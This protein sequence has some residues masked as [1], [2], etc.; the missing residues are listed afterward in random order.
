MNNLRQMK[1]TL[2]DVHIM[3]WQRVYQVVINTDE[4]PL[5]RCCGDDGYFDVGGLIVSFLIPLKSKINSKFN[6]WT[7]D[8]I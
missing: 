6:R 4:N 2:A 7:Y 8:L 3:T 5:H 1:E